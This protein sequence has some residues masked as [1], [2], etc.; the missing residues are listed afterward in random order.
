MQP[1]L[2]PLT[3]SDL[4][5][6]FHCCHQVLNT[7]QRYGNIK[8]FKRRLSLA[9]DP[10]YSVKLSYKNQIIGGYILN[11]K[12]T[13]LSEFNLSPRKID[14]I[15]STLHRRPLREQHKLN[16]LLKT[17]ELYTGP[18]IQ[19]HALFLKSEFRNRGWGRR[20]IEYPYSLYP[21]FE[22][23]WGGQEKDLFNLYDWLKRRSLFYADASCFYTIASLKPALAK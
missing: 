20:L 6:Y 21:R 4:D 13:L 14:R 15:K 17:L 11:S 7:D 2:S 18:G 19:G 23:I 3:Q 9:F 10:G 12:N 5:A 16:L 8:I 22:Y 1:Q